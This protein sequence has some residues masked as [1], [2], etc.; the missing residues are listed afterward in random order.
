MPDRWKLG[1]LAREAVLNVFGRGARMLP[2]LAAA[3]LL[4]AA[5][6]ALLSLE[7]DALMAEV[8]ALTQEGMGVIVY[9]E[10]SDTRPSTITRESCERLSLMPGVEAAGIVVRAGRVR[11]IPLAIDAH[12]QRASTTLFPELGDVDVLVGSTLSSADDEFRI[13]V[14]GQ[15]FV[16]RVAPTTREGTGAS[17]QLTFPLLP[18]D[19]RGTSC[20]VILE[21]LVRPGDV[22]SAQLA[23]L[24]ISG[25]P[26]AGREAFTGT[27]DPIADYLTRLTRYAP[28]AVGLVGGALT[29]LII[30]SRSSE[31]AVYRLSGT[32]RRSLLTLIAVESLLISGVAGSASACAALVLA[33]KLLDPTTAIVSGIALA[34]VWAAVACAATADLAFRRPTDLAKD[35]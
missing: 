8:T 14:D 16:A 13:L 11:A 5:P 21:P 17:F 20:Y 33:G 27:S 12:S 9:T 26:V 10:V 29:A 35:R 18:T 7:Q 28:V 24:A 30:R 6:V 25:N 32:S 19:T 4:G 1:Y 22:I 34:G 23:Q 31:V 3:G 15:S 2:A